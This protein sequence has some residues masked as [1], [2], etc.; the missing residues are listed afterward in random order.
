MHFA[1]RWREVEVVRLLLD[2]GACLTIKDCQGRVAGELLLDVDCVTVVHASSN[3]AHAGRVL[4]PDRGEASE[5][6]Q[7]S[8]RDSAE[9]RHWIMFQVGWC[10]VGAGVDG[11]RHAAGPICWVAGWLHAVVLPVHMWFI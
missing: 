9:Y 7:S 6:W 5:C 8:G 10:V 1:A 2:A 4:Q 3:L 11:W